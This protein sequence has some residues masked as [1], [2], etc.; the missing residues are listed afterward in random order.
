MEFFKNIF[1]RLIRE[2]SVA[3]ITSTY[4]LLLHLEEHWMIAVIVTALLLM[5]C[6]VKNAPLADC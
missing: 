4:F 3:V 2:V 1:G 6:Q 5:L